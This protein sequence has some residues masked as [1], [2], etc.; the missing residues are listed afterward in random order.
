MKYTFLICTKNSERL[1]KDVLE[2]IINQTKLNFEYNVLI[3]DYKSSDKT[4]EISKK[5]CRLHDVSLSILESES[6]GKSSALELG[7]DTAIGEYVIILD[8][9]NIIRSDYLCEANKI[10]NNKIGCLGARGVADAELDYPSWFNR[11]QGWY[12]VGMAGKGKFKDWV[13]G[14]GTIVNKNAWVDIRNK[15]FKFILNPERKSQTHPIAIG[16]EDV[17]LALAIKLAGYTIKSNANLV[18]TH[19]FKQDRLTL[20]YLT[21][22]SYG[23]GKS[24][25]IHELYKMIITNENIRMPKLMWTQRISRIMVGYLY[26][27]IINLVKFNLIDSKFNLVILSAIFAGHNLFKKEFHDFYNN[28]TK[29]KHKSI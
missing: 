13:W 6:G 7:L 17:E 10:I 3:V 21:N 1:I 2:S 5:V 9:D 23:V 25:V 8:D 24:H 15:G 27:T 29:L 12:A 11:Y 4:L 18:Y 20:N 26:R 14:A 28:I 16:G 19:K 22:N